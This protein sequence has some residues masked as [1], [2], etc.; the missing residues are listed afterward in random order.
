MSHTD[1]CRFEEDVFLAVMQSRW[2]GRADAELRAHVATCAICAE[3]ALVAGA[4]EC[5]AA[6]TAETALVPG[7]LPDSGRVWWKAQ[8]RA[9][10][11]ALEA[12]AR[13]ITVVH[14]TACASATAVAGACIGASSE[15]V[16]S[17][18]RWLWGEASGFDYKSLV[19]AALALIE[20]HGLLAAS[21]IAMVL[22]IPVALYLVASRE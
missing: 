18:F 7:T 10:R 15:W 5:A 22:V 12:V 8:M 19:P 9:R 2:P 17:A 3:V 11:E 1:E 4:I 6:A 21:M 14:V 16:Q 13:P 20:S